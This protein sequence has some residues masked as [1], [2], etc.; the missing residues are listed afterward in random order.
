MARGNFYSTEQIDA[1]LIEKADRVPKALVDTNL[2]TLLDTGSYWQSTS[3]Y[4]TVERGYP[5]NGMLGVL[6]V[7]KAAGSISTQE[8][9][10]YDST[11][12]QGV[13][14]RTVYSDGK[15]TPWSAAP[16]LPK[17]LGTMDLNALMSPGTYYQSFAGNSTVERGYPRAGVLGYLNVFK[18]SESIVAQEFTQ[19]DSTGVK[20]VYRRTVYASGQITAWAAS[21]ETIQPLGQTNLDG[22]TS[23]GSYFQSTASLA[24]LER[25]YPKAGMLAVLKVYQA[26]STIVT[27]EITHYDSTGVQGVYYRT[28]YSDGKVTNW[29]QIKGGS[30]TSPAPTPP[31][32]VIPAAATKVSPRRGSI[33]IRFDDDFAGLTHAAEYM[34]QFGFSAYLAATPKVNYPLDI[35]TLYTQYGWEIGNHTADHITINDSKFL[36]SVDEGSRMIKE[37]TGEYPVTFTYPKGYRNPTMDR[38]IAMRFNYIQL[39]SEPNTSAINAS[40]PVTFMGWTVIDG[41]AT[42]EVRARSTDKLKRYVVGSTSQNLIPTLAFH[43]VAKPGQTPTSSGMVP[44]DWF[45]EIIDWLAS[46]GIET[47]LPRMSRPAQIVVDHGFNAYDVRSF[48]DGYFPWA[49]SSANIWSRSITGQYSGHGCLKLSSN[50]AVTGTVS[51]GLALEP[52]RTYRIHALINTQLTS[53]TV[54]VELRPRLMD[55]RYVGQTI[56]LITADSLSSGYKDYSA[57]FQMPS[58]SQNASIFVTANSAIGNALVDH[59]SIMRADFHDPLNPNTP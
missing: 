59:V 54:G 49:T 24:T 22:L 33:M 6:E 48:S 26:A 58:G 25:G 8:Y 35:Q 45:T 9:T 57:E 37:L 15:F 3:S 2:N 13:Y 51:Q 46:R 42:P 1:L 29:T 56:P 27:Q 32:T 41:L 31:V 28:V 23:P 40:E 39:I 50:S 53:G 38:E 11:G 7:R 10:H 17:A 34:A 44:W 43:E 16:G 5:R 12:V 19:Y 30:E 18:T 55:G 47:M 20:G 36:T 14:H 52:G 4:A 21:S